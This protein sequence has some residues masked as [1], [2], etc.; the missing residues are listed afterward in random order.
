M[1]IQNAFRLGLVGTLGVGLGFLILTSIVSLTTIIT[2]IGAALFISLGLDPAITL[3]EKLRFP[4]W[5]AILTVLVV[6]LAAFVG[7]LLAIVPIITTQIGELVRQIPGIVDTVQKQDWIGALN[8]QFGKENVDSVINSI[9]AFVTDPSKISGLASGVLAVGFSIV[10]GAFGGLIIVILTIYFTASLPS[11]KRGMYQLV[12]ASKRARFAD[13][14]EQITQSVGR[15]VM[16]QVALA[17]CNGVLSFIFLTIIGAPFT[18]V[19]AVVAFLFSLIPLVGTLSGSV[20][21]VL[22]CLIPGVGSSPL[23]ALVAAIYY[24]I[25]MQVEA[26]VLSPNIMNRAVSVPGAI[27]VIAALAGGSLLGILG[28]LIAIPVAASILLIIKQV[29]IPRQNEL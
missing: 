22:T 11:I 10:S 5:A 15:Y 27:V 3:L 19:L 16:G 28:A 17:L 26:Y 18:A 8:H 14:S 23:T 20:I 2:Y 6:V 7:V 9:T 21:I 13:I 12:P 25:Y 1:K 29:V 4:R 24:I